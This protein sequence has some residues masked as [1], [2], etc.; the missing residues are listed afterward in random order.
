MSLR[1]KRGLRLWM[2]NWYTLY[3]PNDD[4]QKY[5][6]TSLN[7]TILET[8]NQNSIKILKIILK[9]NVLWLSWYTIASLIISGIEYLSVPT[10]LKIIVRGDRVV[11]KLERQKKIMTLLLRLNKIQLSLKKMK[12]LWYLIKKNVLYL[13]RYPFRLIYFQ[14]I[15]FVV[16][17]TCILIGLPL[18]WL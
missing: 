4:K 6:L 7:T 9:L 2:I 16:K 8:M 10:S 18:L 14:V 15:V 1:D 12:I 5:W 11:L 13:F 3:I 17:F